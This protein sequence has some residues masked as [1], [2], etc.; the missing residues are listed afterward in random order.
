M[1]VTTSLFTG[2]LNLFLHQ[3]YVK[4]KGGDIQVDYREQR[5]LNMSHVKKASTCFYNPQR[6][7]CADPWSY[8]QQWGPETTLYYLHTTSLC[9]AGCS[10]AF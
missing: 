2:E 5:R 7:L 8:S 1:R 10:F 6:S 9:P 4:T 3:I